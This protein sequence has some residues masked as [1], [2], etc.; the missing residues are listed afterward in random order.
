[1]GVIKSWKP[2]IRP[3]YELQRKLWL[4]SNHFGNEKSWLYGQSC[5][6]RQQQRLMKSLVLTARIVKNGSIFLIGREI[7]KQQTTLFN[8][9]FLGSSQTNGKVLYGCDRILPFQQ[10]IKAFFF[11]FLFITSFRRLCIS[12]IIAYNLSRWHPELA[13]HTLLR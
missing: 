3:L 5:G 1:M 4:S 12:E 6:P 9:N 2:K 11:L 7:G 13:R 8:A 10:A